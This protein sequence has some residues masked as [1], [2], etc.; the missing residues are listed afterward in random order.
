ALDIGQGSV[1]CRGIVLALEA[2]EGTDAMLDRVAGLPAHLRGREGAREGVLVKLS[3]PG[4]ERRVDLPTLGLTT[5]EKVAAAGL[6]GIAAEAGGTLLVV[7]EAGARA[8]IRAG[9]FVLG[10]TPERIA[11]ASKCLQAR[12][13]KSMSCWSP[14]KLP[15]MRLALNLWWRCASC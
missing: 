8:A 6:A 5:V 9:I 10:L 13:R 4:Q 1:A 7:S 15:A 11:K 12:R 14:V 2:A 3:K